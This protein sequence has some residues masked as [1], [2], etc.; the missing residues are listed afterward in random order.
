M[1]EST[2]P[3]T[4]T[5]PEAAKKL[6]TEPKLFRRFLRSNASPISAVGQGAR[7]AID[8]K[9]LPK[10]KKEFETWSKAEAAKRAARA[11]AKA[12]AAAKTTEPDADED[13]E[14]ETD[15][16]KPERTQDA[17]DKVIAEGGLPKAEQVK[18]N[19]RRTRKAAS[20]AARTPNARQQSKAIRDADHEA[21]LAEE[22]KLTA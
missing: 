18:A 19:A 7:Y 20:E 15:D 3:T 4:I 17:V 10:L 9:V 13:T 5:A 22:A 21:K 16:P 1:A 8:P 11:E 14:D 6:G 2:A 12:E